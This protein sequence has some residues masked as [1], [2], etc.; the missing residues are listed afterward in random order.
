MNTASKTLL[1]LIL[2]ALATTCGAANTRLVLLRSLVIPGWGELSMG[3]PSGYV[4]LTTEVMLWAGRYYF[5]NESDITESAAHDFAVQWSGIR[6]GNYDEDYW[7]DLVRYDSSGYDAGGYNESVLRDALSR[8]PD[9]P[10]AQQAYIDEHAYSDMYAWDWVDR[11]H[12][13]RFSSMRSDA[14]QYS[15]YAKTVTGIIVANH[16]LSVLNTLRSARSR[17]RLEV[18]VQMQ[19]DGTPCLAGTLHF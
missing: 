3:D 7:L 14:S 19:T 13:A 2:L 5:T 17:Q 1:L 12:R 16:L 18:G 6:P 15:D 9:D 4:F 11:E 8:Y 10:E